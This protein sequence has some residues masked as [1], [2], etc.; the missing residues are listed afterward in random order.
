MWVFYQNTHE[1]VKP[2]LQ[3]VLYLLCLMYGVNLFFVVIYS[4]FVL[5]NRSVKENEML[6]TD[7]EPSTRKPR[8]IDDS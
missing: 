4:W 2:L 1:S 7:M 5:V 3:C 6:T 8:E